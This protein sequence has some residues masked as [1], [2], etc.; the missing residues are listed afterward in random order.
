M[1]RQEKIATKGMGLRTKLVLLLLA[2]GSL[3]YLANV[4]MDYFAASA[5]LEDR[6]TAQLESIRELKKSQ[7]VKYLHDRQSDV[8]MLAEIVQGLRSEAIKK[9]KGFEKNKKDSVERF[10]RK[11]YAD[12]GVLAGDLGSIN[13]LQDFSQAFKEEGGKTGGSMWNG[14]KE[15]YDPM[16]TN[17]QEL[18]GY[19]DLML[20]TVDGDIV[21]S[22]AEESDLGQNVVKGALKDSPAGRVFVKALKEAAL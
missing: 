4:F 13:A 15:K 2:V 5:A 12:V 21:Y 22:S 19:Y 20:V 11:R 14:A 3:P 8:S 1:R 18:H 6:A 16:L 10:L 17:F 9:L 7:I